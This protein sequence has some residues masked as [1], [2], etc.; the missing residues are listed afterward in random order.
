MDRYDF[1]MN[2]IDDSVMGS[3][4]KIEFPPTKASG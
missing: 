3:D 1:I 2:L 4:K